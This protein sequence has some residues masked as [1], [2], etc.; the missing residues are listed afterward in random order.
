MACKD[1]LGNSEVDRS[2]LKGATVRELEAILQDDDIDAADKKVIT[3]TI[4]HKKEQIK[5]AEKRGIDTDPV[6]TATAIAATQAEL[7]AATVDATPSP[8]VLALDGNKPSAPPPTDSGATFAIQARTVRNTSST[9]QRR[10]DNVFS[11]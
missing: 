4:A 8:Q 11:I 9:L 3:E 7:D 10:L 5:L 2:K 6:P 1:W